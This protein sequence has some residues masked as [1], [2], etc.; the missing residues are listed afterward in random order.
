MPSDRSQARKDLLRQEGD[1][2]NTQWRKLS[3]KQQLR[4]LKKR[5]GESVKQR[6]RIQK[7]KQKAD[8]KGES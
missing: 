4:A 6:E 8:K 2:R 1:E 7:Q 5:P 3:F